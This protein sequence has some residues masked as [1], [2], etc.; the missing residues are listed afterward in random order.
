[1]KKKMEKRFAVF[2][3]LNGKNLEGNLFGS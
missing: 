2:N 3:V 1:M